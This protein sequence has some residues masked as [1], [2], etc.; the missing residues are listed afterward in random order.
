MDNDTALAEKGN[1][2]SELIGQPVEV[3]SMEG[4]DRYV[5]TGTLESYVYPWVLLRKK[6]G[7]LLSFP[8]FNIRIIKH[9]TRP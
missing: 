5:D 2:L 1:P 6:T 7:E 4:H 8:V 3:T 9:T